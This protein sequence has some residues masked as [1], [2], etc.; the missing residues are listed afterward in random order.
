[1]PKRRKDPAADAF[2]TAQLMEM[3]ALPTVEKEGWSLRFDQEGTRIW[4]NVVS[5]ECC[6]DTRDDKGRWTRKTE[7][8]G[9]EPAPKDTK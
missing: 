7:W 9:G 3:P 4:L 8:F 6:M 1:M 2:T 5:G